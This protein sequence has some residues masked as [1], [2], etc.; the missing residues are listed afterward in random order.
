MQLLPNVYALIVQ[1]VVGILPIAPFYGKRKPARQ[2]RWYL[3][4]VHH[5]FVQACAICWEANA[6]LHWARREYG[7]PLAVTGISW[8]GAMAALTARL[9]P[10]DLAVV[11][12]M[13]CIG[14]GS[15]FADG[16]TQRW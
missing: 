5:S 4:L 2:S 3:R 11:P 10:G 1:G 16:A 15:A 8:G 13:G 12:Y 9:F 6:L 14:P 7:A